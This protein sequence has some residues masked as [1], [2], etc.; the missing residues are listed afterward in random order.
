ML[1]MRLLYLT[2]LTAGGAKVTKRFLWMVR[3]FHRALVQEAKIIMVMPGVAL[4]LFH[5]RLL[6]SPQAMVVFTQA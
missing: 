2:R 5:T 6:H 4:K 1:A 3:N